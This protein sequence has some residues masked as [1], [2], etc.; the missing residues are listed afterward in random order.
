M[1]DYKIVTMTDLA[2]YQRD[3]RM[4]KVALRIA[5]VLVVVTS[6]VVG[7]A[8]GKREAYLEAQETIENM[9]REYGQTT[10]T[11]VMAWKEQTMQVQFIE[12]FAQYI[13]GRQESIDNNRGLTRLQLKNRKGIDP[14][15]KE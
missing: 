15:G 10:Q 7:N 2:K 6:F 5:L 14:W 9:Q 12:N 3:S 8:I 1:E 13:R 4:G 11:F